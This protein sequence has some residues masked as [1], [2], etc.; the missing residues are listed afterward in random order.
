[1][2]IMESFL[3]VQVWKEVVVFSMRLRNFVARKCGTSFVSFEVDL[4]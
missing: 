3:G 4:D 1:M 2:R